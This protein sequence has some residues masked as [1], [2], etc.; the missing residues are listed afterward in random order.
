MKITLEIET[1]DKSLIYELLGKKSASRGDKVT[2]NKNIELEYQGT[3]IQL[4]EG[5]PDVIRLSLE[6]I[7][8]TAGIIKFADWLYNKIKNKASKLI[9]DRTVIKIDK[10]EIKKIII[11]KIE[12]K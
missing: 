9:I 12:K 4:A 8:G 7:G 3:L 11:E 5:I 2:I 6:I 1:K 10:G